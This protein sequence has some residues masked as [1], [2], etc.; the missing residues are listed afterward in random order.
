VIARAGP[1]SVHAL[2]LAFAAFALLAG[3]L[4]LPLDVPPL[5]LFDCP[6]RLA[7]GLPCFACGMTHAF[8]SLVRFDV[9]DALLASPLGAL[10]AAACAVHAVW[11]LLRLLGLPWAPH[12]RPTRA[13]RFSAAAAL[14]A[15]WAFIA[16]RGAR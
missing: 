10:L 12:V 6:F 5:S 4:V 9:R 11:T 8:H 15:N 1:P 7:T 16:L 3:A 14:A 2:G 13:L